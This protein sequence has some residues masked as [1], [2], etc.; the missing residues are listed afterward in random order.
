MKVLPDTF[1]PLVFHVQRM[2]CVVVVVGVLRMHRQMRHLTGA[3]RHRHRA[4]HRHGLP[5]KDKQKKECAKANRHAINSNSAFVRAATRMT[6]C[7][8]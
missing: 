4:E 7:L 8:E 3:L 6:V 5:Q 2:V 1:V